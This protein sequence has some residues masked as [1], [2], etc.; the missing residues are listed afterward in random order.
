MTLTLNDTE[1][2][3]N[4]SITYTYL[5]DINM[6]ARK[7]LYIDRWIHTCI[8]NSTEHFSAVNVVFGSLQVTLKV[9]K[10]I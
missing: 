6:T 5:W 8:H 7:H 2:S 3:E 1:K 9:Q 10:H 4:G